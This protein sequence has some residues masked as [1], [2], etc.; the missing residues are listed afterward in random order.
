MQSLI[1]NADDFGLTR[2]VNEGIVRAH[3][4]GIVTSTTIMADAPAFEHAVELARAAPSLDVG[5]HLVLWPESTAMPQRL[6]SF[7]ARALG[8]SVR[9]IEDNFARQV[10][11]VIE[12]GIVPSHLDTHKHTHLLPNVMRAV[13]RVARRFGIAWVRRALFGWQATSAGL[14]TP[15]HFVGIRLTGHMEESSLLA[16]LSKLRPGVTEL[17]CHPGLCDDDLRRAPTRLREHRER[18]LEALTSGNV[19]DFLQRRGIELTSCRQLEKGV[20][21][22]VSGVREVLE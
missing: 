4:D 1:V 10:E 14:K 13:T 22:K 5:V 19:R 12:A 9:E 8:S 11:R 17:M 20:R 18:E 7:V 6:P 15:D 3:H 2:G 16:A 21:C